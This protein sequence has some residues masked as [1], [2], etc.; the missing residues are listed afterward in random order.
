M[1]VSEDIGIKKIHDFYRDLASELNSSDEI[2]LDFVNV[3]RVDLSVIQ[4]II[5][6]GRK[7][8][9]QGKT[10]KLK[11]VSEVIKQQMQVCGL[12]T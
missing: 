12:K 5:A 6:A 4:V 3:A 1:L 9:E 10:I 11:S 8:R 2:V 7:A